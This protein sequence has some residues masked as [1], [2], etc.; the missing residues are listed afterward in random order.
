MISVSREYDT[1]IITLF[2]A[3][4]DFNYRSHWQEGVKAVEEV[5]H[6]LP[7]VGMRCRCILDNGQN[8]IYA[9]SFLYQPEKI[10]FSETDEKE[11]NTS[12]FTLEKTGIKKTKLTLDYYLKKNIAQQLL[13]KL[14]RKKKMED[15]L[16][17]SLQNLDSV[18]KEIKLPAED[19]PET[20]V[21]GLDDPQ[22]EPL[23]K[24]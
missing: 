4:G 13:F 3:A 12:H 22:E 7:R 1:D 16:R 9:S 15:S 14:M 19:W 17:Q 21:P 10:Q 18:V 24:S 8:M 5:S 6:Y 2:H 23:K 20:L 11:G